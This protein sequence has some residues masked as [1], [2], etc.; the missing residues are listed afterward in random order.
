MAAVQCW[1]LCQFA[2]GEWMDRPDE[3]ILNFANSPTNSWIFQVALCLKK[4]NLKLSLCTACRHTG[5]TEVQLHWFL[6]LVLDGG[7]WSTPCP[8]HFTP[9]REY[10]VQTEYEAGQATEMGWTFS[11]RENSL[12]P[13]RP[14]LATKPTEQSHLQYIWSINSKISSYKTLFSY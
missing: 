4:R 5:R 11:T 10:P 7:K 12:A 6:P 1:L 14:S 9:G 8:D 3:A 13:A 2:P